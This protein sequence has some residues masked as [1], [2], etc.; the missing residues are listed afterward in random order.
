MLMQVI[1]VNLLADASEYPLIELAV[2][3]VPS[4]KNRELN[5]ETTRIRINL[6]K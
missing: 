6:P 1:Q 2:T 3:Q 5:D 4:I